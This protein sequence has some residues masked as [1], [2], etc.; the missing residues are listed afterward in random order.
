MAGQK[1]A[2]SVLPPLPKKHSNKEREV[3]SLVAAWLV[4]H[5]TGTKCWL[6]EVKVKGGRL[7]RHQSVALKQVENG[8][9][10]YKFPDQGRKTPCDY[11][12]LGD[13][14]ALVCVV[15]GKRVDCSVNSG[16]RTFRF[17]LGGKTT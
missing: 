16:V 8:T 6:L 7:K 5:Y 10:I 1:N 14:D 17:Y 13:A 3:D 12:H 9:F 4:A 2:R 11:V 15:D